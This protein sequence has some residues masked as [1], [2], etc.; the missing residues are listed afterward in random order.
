MQNTIIGSCFLAG[1]ETQC[2]LERFSESFVT[3]LVLKVPAHIV[4]FG[5]FPREFP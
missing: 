5:T 3:E 4:Q 1:D 2:H